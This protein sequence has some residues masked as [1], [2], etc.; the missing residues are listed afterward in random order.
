MVFGM[1]E[2]ISRLKMLVN[3]LEELE[4]K[5]DEI[6]KEMERLEN[7]GLAKGW[8]E[9][10]WVRNKVGQRY[11]YYY[12]CYR[13]NGKKVSIYLGHEIPED[14]RK[15]LENYRRYRSLKSKLRSLEEKKA[16]IKEEISRLLRN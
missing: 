5:M 6:R 3:E 8:V 14:L 15:K 11:Y 2:Q 10:K 7:E 12:Y 1:S 16:W 9:L 4:K 13:K